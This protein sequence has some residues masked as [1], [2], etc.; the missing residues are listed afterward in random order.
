MLSHRAYMG[1]LIAPHTRPAVGRISHFMDMKSG[2]PSSTVRRPHPRPSRTLS[3]LRILLRSANSCLPIAAFGIAAPPSGARLPLA[4]GAL[5]DE[6][7]RSVAERP[8]GV[9][10]TQ[11]L[12]TKL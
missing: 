1:S 3:R 5:Y 4:R 11:W 12:V 6:H 10:G 2:H 7:M 8:S 9:A